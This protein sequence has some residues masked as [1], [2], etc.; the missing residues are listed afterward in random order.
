MVLKKIKGTLFIVSAPSG[1]G[2]TTLCK[3]LIENIPDLKE[4]VS[5]TTRPPRT[6]EVNNVNYTFITHKQFKQKLEN[7]EFLE[8]AEVF[9]NYYGTSQKRV[10]DIL[11]SGCD[12]LLDIDTQGAIQLKQR[13]KNIVTIFILPPSLEV[14]AQRLKDRNTNTSE[15]IAVRLDK[16]R[17]EIKEFEKYDF[18]VVN[19]ELIKAYKDI[20]S[21]I[22]SNRLK[23]DLLDTDRIEDISKY[24]E[25][26]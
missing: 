6:G 13:M 23:R 5:Y 11:L 1:T 2:K 9:G 19:D 17:A 26:E 22:L 14:L 3:K 24:L 7:N 10:E 4:S 8:Y 15:D 21:I 20:E 16:S 12:V 25:E 18:L